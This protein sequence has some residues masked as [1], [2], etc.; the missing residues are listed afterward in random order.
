MNKFLKELLLLHLVFI[1][2]ACTAYF[3][4]KEK[5]TT[6]LIV[7]ELNIQV[8]KYGKTDTTYIYKF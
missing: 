1:L 2:G 6:K 7:P 5:T 4:E 3:Y 8:E